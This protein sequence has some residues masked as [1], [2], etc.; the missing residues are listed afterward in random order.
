MPIS[1]L[2]DECFSDVLSY[3]DEKSLY[4]WLFVNRYFC[5]FTILLIWREPFVYWNRV[6]ISS[7]NTLLACLN[8]DEISSLIPC[9]IKFNNNQSPL[10]EYGQFI[11]KFN[12]GPCV[13]HIMTLLGVRSTSRGQD[14]RIQKLVNVIYHMI[15]RQ[16][17][18]L[19]EFWICNTWGS[20]YVDLPK[21]STFTAYEPGITNLKI[22]QIDITDDGYDD[23]IDDRYDDIIDGRYKNTIE[24][25]N[26]VSK[27]CNG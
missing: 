27:S 15:M 22:L 13:Y 8:E 14:C 20:I 1:S 5:K 24:F 17:S 12:H 21:L 18:N 2:P 4:K 11:R 10:F 7:I 6:N 3:L 26:M 23:I 19:Q 16:G 25:L 9:A